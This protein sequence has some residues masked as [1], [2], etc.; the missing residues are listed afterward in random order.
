[1]QKKSA[2]DKKLAVGKK[3]EGRKNTPARKKAA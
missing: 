2:S 3:L 1:V